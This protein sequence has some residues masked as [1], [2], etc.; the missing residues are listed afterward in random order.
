MAINRR[1]RTIQE[2]YEKWKRLN[3]KA[4][5]LIRRYAYNALDA[6]VSRWGIKAIVERARWEAVIKT[7]GDDF[8][9]N[10]NWSSRL[11]RDLIAEDERFEALFER[12]RLKAP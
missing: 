7:H 12:R 2:L 10:N 8:K 6:G 1:G 9:F 5:S 3:P 11:V 4:W